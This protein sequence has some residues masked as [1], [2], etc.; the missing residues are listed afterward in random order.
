MPRPQLPRGWLSLG[1]F[2]VARNEVKKAIDA[3]QRGQRCTEFDEKE[4]RMCLFRLCQ[5]QLHEGIESRENLENWVTRSR[6]AKD[7]T[8]FSPEGMEILRIVFQRFL[9]RQKLS[10]SLQLQRQALNKIEEYAI[11][12]AQCKGGITE[13][14]RKNSFIL[15]YSTE[16]WSLVDFLLSDFSNNQAVAN[17]LSKNENT[18]ESSNVANS[19]YLAS[20]FHGSTIA[21]RGDRNTQKTDW[22]QTINFDNSDSSSDVTMS[23]DFIVYSNKQLN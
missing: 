15:D 14:K 4:A 3:Y 23:I 1:D 20:N 13:I 6:K 18:N 11:E 17:L 8:L 12:I 21:R 10:L 9:G 16:L 22:I 7:L 5:L 2:F 19:S